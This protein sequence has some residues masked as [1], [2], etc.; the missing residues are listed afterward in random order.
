MTSRGHVIV[1]TEDSPR[2]RK[3]QVKSAK[4]NVVLFSR[5]RLPN[6]GESGKMDYTEDVIEPAGVVSWQAVDGGIYYLAG[7]QKLHFLA[8]AAVGK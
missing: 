8:G 2:S 3:P 6:G 1:A 7:D 5:S 4:M